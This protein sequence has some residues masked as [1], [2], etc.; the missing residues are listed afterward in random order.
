MR[1]AVH[2]VKNPKERIM[3]HVALVL[4]LSFLF[5]TPLS[6]FTWNS[7]SEQKEEMALDK[8]PEPV[9]GWATLTQ[10][11][12]YPESAK[13]QAIQGT[14]YLSIVVG[15]DGIINKIEVL[16]GIR[17]DLDRAATRALEKSRWI[18]AEAN[19]KPVEARFTIPIEFKLGPKS[20]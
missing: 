6:A 3:R 15:V 13:K 1:E 4:T 10:L 16:Q 2:L 11:V 19:G 12:E 20:K 14:V 17:E 18:P 7:T 5:A 8:M 9:G